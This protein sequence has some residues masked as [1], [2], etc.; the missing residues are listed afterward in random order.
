MLE[1]LRFLPHIHT[2][3]FYPKSFDNINFFLLSKNNE[4]TRQLHSL[5]MTHIYNNEYEIIKTLLESD[6]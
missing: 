3:V 5:C 2:Q 6:K 4:Y 1:L